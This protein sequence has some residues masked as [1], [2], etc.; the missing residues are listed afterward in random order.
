MK[1]GDTLKRG[2]VGALDSH[3]HVVA[4]ETVEEAL[5]DL[6]LSVKIRSNDEIDAYNEDIL[7]EERD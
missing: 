7:A 6:Y 1:P 3:G 2:A 4:S 5:V